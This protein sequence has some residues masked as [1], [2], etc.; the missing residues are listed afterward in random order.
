MT[1]LIVG[2]DYVEPLKREI[3]AHGHLLQ[4]RYLGEPTRSI[5]SVSKRAAADLRHPGYAW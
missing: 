1:A 3:R 2:S 4:G 5:D